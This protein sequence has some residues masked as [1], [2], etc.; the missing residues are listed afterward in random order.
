MAPFG[1]IA[2][3]LAIFLAEVEP[4]AVC[5]AGVQKH[6]MGAGRTVRIGVVNLP[7]QDYH[8][9][10][11][12]KDWLTTVGMFLNESLVGRMDPPVQVVLTQY[13]HGQLLD[14]VRATLCTFNSILVYL[15]LFAGE[16]ASALTHRGWARGATA[17]YAAPFHASDSVASPGFWRGGRLFPGGSWDSL[18]H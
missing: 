16:D 5:P 14:A 11:G 6:A 9:G 17:S 1:V 15:L 8:E 3:L 13:T 18:L 12:V 2:V 4:S 10:W 7:M